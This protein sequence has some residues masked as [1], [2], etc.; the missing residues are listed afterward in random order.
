MVFFLSNM[1]LINLSMSDLREACKGQ[2]PLPKINLGAFDQSTRD[3]FAP[4]GRKCGGSQK[5]LCTG[6]LTYLLTH[7]HRVFVQ[8]F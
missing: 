2:G 7:S 8:P 4:F 1:H 5:I 6:T 3:K